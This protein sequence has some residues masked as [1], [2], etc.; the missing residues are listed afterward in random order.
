MI[1]LRL[2]EHVLLSLGAL[3]AVIVFWEL[4]VRI[5]G[6]SQLIFAPP[7]T[8]ATA[9]MALLG[10]GELPQR[11]FESLQTFALGFGSA[12]I[13]GVLLG[14]LN[15]WYTRVYYSL[16]L[17]LTA[18]YSTPAIVLLPL[19]VIALGPGLP[20]QITIVFLTGFFPIIFTTSSGVRAVDRQ[21]VRVARSLGA[22]DVAIFR[23]VAI[24]GSVPF[25]LSGLRVGLGRS[26][27][28]L[29]FAEWF[30]GSRGIGYLVGL[31]G[32]TFQTARLL[33]MIVIVIVVSLVLVEGMKRLEIR[34]LQRVGAQGTP[35]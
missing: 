18:L 4:L 17:I 31:Y 26:I 23:D 19:F 27:V 32:T 21:L 12:A 11:L 14:L 15:G 10:G 28:G 16:D 8:V 6:V 25:I 22:S 20:S 13:I 35:N 5:G 30:G 2:N 29:L 1:K 7:T 33:A 9:L 3:V 34:Y 24:P